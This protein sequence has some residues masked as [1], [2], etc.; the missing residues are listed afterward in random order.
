[1]LYLFYIEDM[2][3]TSTKLIEHDIDCVNGM[4][5]FLGTRKTYITKNL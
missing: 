2:T 4:T 5:F 1:M 3:S